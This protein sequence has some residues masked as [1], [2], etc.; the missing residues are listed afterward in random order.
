LF[1]PTEFPFHFFGILEVKQ[2]GRFAFEDLECRSGDSPALG[3]FPDHPDHPGRIS[4]VAESTFD[5]SAV[6]GEVLDI[7][8]FKACRIAA[9]WGKGPGGSGRFLP[10]NIIEHGPGF[11][12]VYRFFRR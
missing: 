11:F 2:H 4:H 1:D 12:V 5:A 7:A 3:I 10:S 8:D 9:I 6:F